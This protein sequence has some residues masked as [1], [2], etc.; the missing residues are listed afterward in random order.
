MKVDKHMWTTIAEASM[1][2]LGGTADSYEPQS[3]SPSRCSTCRN[4]SA[5]SHRDVVICTA[6]HAGVLKLTTDALQ[7]LQEYSDFPGV[8]AWRE[9]HLLEFACFD[10]VPFVQQVATKRHQR[11]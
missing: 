7:L 2:L 8:K 10:F 1:L 3:K 5:V 4:V 6:L 11:P 9:A